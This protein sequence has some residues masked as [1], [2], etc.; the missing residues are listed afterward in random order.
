[1]AEELR[2]NTG[3]DESGFDKGLA[4]IQKKVDEVNAKISQSSNK[5]S[6]LVAKEIDRAAQELARLDK[7]IAAQSAK[8]RPDNEYLKQLRDQAW[9][10][11]SY[12]ENLQNQGA[13]A[14]EHSTSAEVVERYRQLKEE[15]QQCYQNMANLKREQIELQKSTTAAPVADTGETGGGGFL[16]KIGS[17]MSTVKDGLTNAFLK[18]KASIGSAKTSLNEFS[19][20]ANNA[21]ISAKA[22]TQS[23]FSLGNI[24][25]GMAKRKLLSTIFGSV[26][27]GL[28]A[29]QNST[30]SAGAGLRGLASAGAY[31]G[32]SIAAAIAPLAGMILP[33]FNAITN[34]IASAM[35]ALARFLALLGG[36]TTY[37]KAV[38]QNVSV[39]GSAGKVAKQATKAAEAIKEEE[40]AERALASFD[41]INQLNLNK[42][43]AGDYATPEIETP[44]AGGGGG[45]GGGGLAFVEEAIQPTEFMMELAERLQRIWGNLVAIVEALGEKWRQ[46]WEFNGNGEIIL[47]TLKEILWDILDCIEHITEY[48]LDWVQNSL[49]LTP[50]VTGIKDVLVALEPV[51]QLIC[52]A[53]EWV[54]VNVILP[55]SEWI[56]ESALPEILETI[57]TALNTIKSIMEVVG[58]ILQKIFEN[59]IKPI[60]EDLGQAFLDFLTWVN[61]KL[62]ELATWVTENQEKMEGWVILIL[63]FLAAILLVSAA[64]AAWGAIVA[65]CTAAVGL[66]TNPIT[67][68]VVAV[69]ALIA[70]LVKLCGSWDNVKI[71]AKN[72]INGIIGFVEKGF[73]GAI[74]GIESFLNW[75]IGGLNNLISMAS[76]IGEFFGFGSLGNIGTV[77]LG[78]IKI[79]RLATGTVIPP[80]AGEF[81]AILG[82]NNADTEI[83]SPLDTMKQAFLEAISE[84]GGLGGSNVVIKFDGTMGELVRMLKPELDSETRRV[85]VKLVTE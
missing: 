8:K 14:L 39:A 32:N 84:S 33:V 19:S 31:A 52:D 65:I 45:G 20:Q 13:V 40:K 53:I 10:V 50:L 46:A 3:V 55:L 43:N 26:T 6:T 34:A 63:S 70:I 74:S 60:A 49:D 68:V 59:F 78:R 4:N 9:E 57:A 72:A 11:R 37:T 48:T 30:L 66:L 29:L 73:N 62:G 75:V 76:G 51:V 17:L 25:L 56:L 58:P 61:E 12:M 35:N 27:S 2:F 21:G 85:G 23:I 16:S 79:P 81:A 64:M 38:K 22:L 44:D 42:N 82:D 47:N 36:K 1:M 71:A 67:L 24:F 54:W 5:T 18:A 69:A 15:L 80:S 28:T 41:E 7:Q 83:V 77:K